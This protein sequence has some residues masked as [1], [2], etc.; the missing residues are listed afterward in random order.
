MTK[1]EKAMGE[2]LKRVSK[3]C[4]NDDMRTQMNKIEFLG[5]RVIG[6]PES[7]M[8]VLSLWL[9]KKSWKVIYVNSNMKNERVSLPKTRG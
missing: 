7:C 9:M 5:K 1:G 2:I 6:T 8:R 4:R 3:E